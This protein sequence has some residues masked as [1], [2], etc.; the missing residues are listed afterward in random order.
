MTGQFINSTK[1]VRRRKGSTPWFAA[2]FVCFGAGL[3]V[4]FGTAFLISFEYLSGEAGRGVWL[5][6]VAFALLIFGAH[7]LD[8]YDESEKAARLREFQKQLDEEALKWRVF[9]TS[10]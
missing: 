5:F 2:A 10:L 9:T 3:V 7:C 1:K 8:K 6:L 4:L